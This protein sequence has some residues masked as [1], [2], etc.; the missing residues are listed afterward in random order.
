MKLFSVAALLAVFVLPV[1][2]SAQQTQQIPPPPQAP[3]SGQQYG[4]PYG[5]QGQPYGQQGQPYGQPG[6]PQQ[7]GERRYNR[8]MRM[9]SRLNL[10][11]QQQQQVQSALG[12]YFQSHPAGSAR[13]PQGMR[14]LRDQI[15][16]TLSPSQQDQLRSQ[17]QAAR[18]QRLQRQLQR[19]QQQGQAPAYN[20][21]QPPR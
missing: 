14:N 8:W 16:G 9:L 3:P 12:Q 4:Q 6:G 7:R 10:S 2:V 1:A 13:D 5:Q 11:S 17:M 21:T 19:A 15:F 18:V 20:G